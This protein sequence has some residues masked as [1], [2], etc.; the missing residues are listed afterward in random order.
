MN[1]QIFL[2]AFVLYIIAMIVFGWWVSRHK[3][4]SGD[5][6]FAW[7]AKCSPISHRGHHGRHNGGYRFQHGGPLALVMQMAGRGRSTVSVV[8][9]GCFYSPSAL[10]LCVNFAS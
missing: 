2:A 3:R 10:P 1:S 5:D 9:L 8:P 6:F 4:G 7:R